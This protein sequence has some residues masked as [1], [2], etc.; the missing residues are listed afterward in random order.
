MESKNSGLMIFDELDIQTDIIGNS[1]IDYHPTTSLQSGAP[2]EFTIPGSTDEYI[3]LANIRLE[4]CIKVKKVVAGKVQPLVAAD[5]VAL[6]NQALSSL[7]Q[8]IYLSIEGKQIEGGQHMY[9]YLA[10]F[11]SLL[12]FHPSAKKTHMQALG[13]NEDEPNKMDSDTNEGFKFRSEAIVDDKEW[14]LVGPLFL[15]MTRQAK[16]LLSKTELSFKLIRSKTAFVIHQLAT[17]NVDYQIDF[18]ECI[19]WVPRVKV[20]EQVIVQHMKGLERHN[21]IYNLQHTHLQ[22]I[23][24]N[25]GQSTVRK[26]GLFTSQCPKKLVIGLLDHEAFNG[27]VGLNPFNFEHFNLRRVALYRDGDL[28][29]GQTSIMDYEKK[30]YTRAYVNSQSAL[31]YFNTDDTNGLT[32]EH[33]ENGYNLYVFDLTPDGTSDSTHRSPMSY[34]SLRLELDFAKALAKPI[35][36]LMFAVFDATLELTKLRDCI[37]SYGR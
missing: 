19:L 13:W 9:P 2:P 31:G 16:Y 17:A 29:P 7:F 22:S 21:A 23:T 10:Y 4:L 14:N 18:T 26:D 27:K 12:Q 32:M 28:T 37:V 25:S 30:R 8:D 5:K 33:F 20:N 34:S 36:V 24:V 11:C 6:V 1:T 3:D 15:N 35:T